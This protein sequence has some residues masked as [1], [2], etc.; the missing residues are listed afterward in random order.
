MILFHLKNFVEV[1][2][3]PPNSKNKREERICITL[4]N[5]TRSKGNRRELKLLFALSSSLPSSK[6]EK[7][8][9]TG[10][11]PDSQWKYLSGEWFYEA[12][13]RRHMDKIHGSEIIL[14]SMKAQKAP[15]GV[16]ALHCWHSA[17]VRVHN[18]VIVYIYLNHSASE[19]C[20]MCVW[21]VLFPLFLICF[22]NADGSP[23]SKRSPT[24][25]SSSLKVGAPPKPAR[26]L[27]N[28]QLAMIKYAVAAKLHTQPRDS[29]V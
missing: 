10:S 25:S 19:L 2:K 15:F 13:S 4:F 18:P 7:M 16:F 8:H 9:N 23:L 5:S 26:S 17:Y 3:K 22:A 11:E 14:A 21:G 12:K 1:E 27:E 6:L 20:H 29:P 28:L 24:P